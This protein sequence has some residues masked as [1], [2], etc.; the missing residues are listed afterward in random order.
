MLVQATSMAAE[1]VGAKGNLGI[2]RA[3]AAADLLVVDGDPLEDI[4][5][6][7]AD[8]ANLRIIMKEGAFVKN[9]LGAP[10]R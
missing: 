9:E 3:G 4:D 7:V 5:C 1:I 6:L 10:P 2:V 8:G